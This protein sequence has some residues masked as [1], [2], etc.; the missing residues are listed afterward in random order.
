MVG[1]SGGGK[2]QMMLISPIA[3]MAEHVGRTS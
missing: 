3:E 1:R 2:D